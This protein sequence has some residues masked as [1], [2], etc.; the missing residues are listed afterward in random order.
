MNHSQG[1]T[2]TRSH[3]RDYDPYPYDIQSLTESHSTLTLDKGN[4]K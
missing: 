1:C 3:N 4:K 2:S